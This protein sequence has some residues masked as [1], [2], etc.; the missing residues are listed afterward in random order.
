MIAFRE[1]GMCRVFFSF[2]FLKEGNFFIIFCLNGFFFVG[3]ESM[4]RAIFF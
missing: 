3:I 1:K 2:F 4:K